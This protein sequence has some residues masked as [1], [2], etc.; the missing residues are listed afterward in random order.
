MIVTVIAILVLLFLILPIVILY[1]ISL[2]P[3]SYVV[4]PN[5]GYSTQWFENFFRIRSG[6]TR[7]RT[8]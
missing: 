2:S 3:T 7:F 5:K 8:A 1:P 4:F 6:L